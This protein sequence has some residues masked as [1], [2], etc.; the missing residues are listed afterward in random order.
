MAA[1]KLNFD[2]LRNAIGEILESELKE[3][4]ADAKGD[5]KKYAMRIANDLAEAAKAGRTDLIRY[6]VDQ[7]RMVAELERITFLNNAMDMV[8]KVISTAGAF[9]LKL[10]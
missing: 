8:S 2:E 4:V 7:A 1:S 9:A 5:L 3:F 6:C 10:I